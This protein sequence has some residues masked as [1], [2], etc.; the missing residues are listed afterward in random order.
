M[1]IDIGVETEMRLE[2]K[3]N[4]RDVDTGRMSA[5]D[6][7]PAVFGMGRMVA[8]ASRVLYADDRIRLDVSAE[9]RRGSFGLELFFV[10]WPSGLIPALN[11]QDLANVAQILG[12][13]VTGVATGVISLFRWQRGRK[14]DRVE[15]VDGGDRVRMTIEDQSI[16]VT[17]NEFKIF[18]DPEVRKGIKLVA[19]PLERP[20]VDSVDFTVENQ[21]TQRI[22]RA[23][24]DIFLNAPALDED[25]DT[26]RVTA[27]LEIVQPSLR[28][29]YM[30]R[31]A[32]GNET[33]QAE[34]ADEAFL[35]RVA[36]REPFAAGDAL[37][38]EMDV[39]TTRT[40]DGWRYRRKIIRVTHHFPNI[41]G[42]GQLPLI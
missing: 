8:E 1:A 39:T 19:E 20:G 17:I 25:I 16:N 32:Q 11:L 23:E 24:R 5:L 40:T 38:V 2:V 37:R 34:V 15:R 7:G 41:P 30:W 4:G 27:I 21:P 14:I 12:F 6:L 18:A 22:E 10:S 3:Y 42:G 31:F 35:R 33:F 26:T 9:I 29:D 28:G 36:A 13:G